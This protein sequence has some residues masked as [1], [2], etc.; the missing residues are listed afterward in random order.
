MHRGI[1]ILATLLALLAGCSKPP[2][3]SKAK[4]PTIASLMPGA[5]SLIVEMG[6]DD[7]LV[8]VSQF[9]HI[10]PQIANL[11][12][13]GD[14]ANVDWERLRLIKPDMLIVFI[15]PDRIPADFKRRAD[16]QKMQLVNIRTERVSEIFNEITHLGQLLNETEKAQTLTQKIQ[17]KLDQ[18]RQQ[19]ANRP[20]VR[21]LIVHDAEIQGV[22]GQNTFLNDLLEIAGGQ[23]V[24]TQSGWIQMDRE[25]IRAAKPDVILHLLP[26]ATEAS[27]A[28]AQNS[29]KQMN[30]PDAKIRFLRN[31]H[32]LQPGPHIAEVAEEFQKALAE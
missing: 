5:T 3:P 8:G 28:Q 11:P 22:V 1:T 13:V 2:V 18:T 10:V 30:L 16:D 7:H 32:L 20:K 19:S 15:S 9:D 21:V 24:V 27:V 17:S 25:Q 4:S 14:Y 23:N 31:W 6:A 26:E 12:K 29:W